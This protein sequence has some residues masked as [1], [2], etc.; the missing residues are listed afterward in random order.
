MNLT[1]I[2][3]ELIFPRNAPTLLDIFMIVYCTFQRHQHAK[4]NITLKPNAERDVEFPGFG[5][6]LS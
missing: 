2:F 5:A 3:D 1:E 4:V 6:S